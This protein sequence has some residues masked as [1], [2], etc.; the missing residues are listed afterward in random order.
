MLGKNSHLF[1]QALENA[2]E[3]F[4]NLYSLWRRGFQGLEKTGDLKWRD[5]MQ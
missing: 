5:D 4:L 2:V 1:F 3:M